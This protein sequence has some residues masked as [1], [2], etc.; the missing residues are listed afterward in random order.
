MFVISVSFYQCSIARLFENNEKSR[1]IK[2]TIY[3]EDYVHTNVI[4]L[5]KLVFLQISKY[6]KPLLVSN[7]NP[8][9]SVLIVNSSFCEFP[10][11]NIGYCEKMCHETTS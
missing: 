4:P 9:Q 10:P 1:K 5:S 6:N 2:K 7:Y 11:S 3:M 8:F